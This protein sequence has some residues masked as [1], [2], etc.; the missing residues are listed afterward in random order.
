VNLVIT[1]YV[2][3]L[4]PSEID[5][6]QIFY[7]RQRVPTLQALCLALRGTVIVHSSLDCASFLFL[8]WRGSV[9]RVLRAFPPSLFPPRAL[10]QFPLGVVAR[11]VLVLEG[12][13]CEL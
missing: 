8:Q 12:A 1:A 3:I 13:L 4:V 11:N 2:E 6:N 7:R 9:L 5:L 10:P